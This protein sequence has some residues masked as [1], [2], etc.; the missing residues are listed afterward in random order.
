MDEQSF[1]IIA[2]LYSFIFLLLVLIG[3]YLIYVLYTKI[4]QNNDINEMQENHYEE[5]FPL[6]MFTIEDD[7]FIEDPY[8]GDTEK[9]IEEPNTTQASGTMH[10]SSW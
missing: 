10:S 3:L 1:I 2:L 9:Q 8:F 4:N 5:I 7:G 6:S